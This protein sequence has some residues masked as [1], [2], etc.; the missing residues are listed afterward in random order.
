[1]SYAEY[2]ER[3]RVT[4]V[5]HEWLRGEVWAM[6]GGT[7]DHSGI[8]ANVIQELGLALR[9]RPCRVYTSDLKLRIDAT[10]RS[11]Y[12]D[13]AVVCGPRE[14]SKADPNAVTN[15]VVI[16]EVLSDST[17]ADD[18]GE[19]FAHYRRLESLRVYLLV[20][21]RER[22]VEVFSRVDATGRWSF[23][24]HAAGARVTLPS[25]DVELEVD[26]LY[27]DPSA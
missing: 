6:A 16:V 25:L 4:G 22:R 3:E 18:R 17:E 15:P 1:M 5:R 20:S 11:T 13:V 26:A 14:V 2:L 19:K 21:Q 24:E 7:P 8:A 9:G 12:P 23:E 10:D 27:R